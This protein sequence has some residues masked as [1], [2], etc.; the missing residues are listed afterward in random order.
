M[1]RPEAKAWELVPDKVRDE[2][3]RRIR[4]GAGNAHALRHTWRLLMPDYGLLAFSY[5][6]HKVLRWMG[7]MLLLTIFISNL[8]FVDRPLGSAL[9][10]AQLA[11]SAV[12]FAAPWLQGIPLVGRVATGVWVFMVLNVAL[13]LG[14]MK[15]LSGRAMP[16]W[17][18]TS[19]TA[20]RKQ[21][22]RMHP[23]HGKAAARSQEDSS[24]A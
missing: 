5:W 22:T 6:S 14:T 9:L 12:G 19:R 15:Y 20:E 16:V 23:G 21:R 1:F 2:F 8:W 18:R 3:R 17:Q 13:L 10:I 24:A 4:V 11:F 7:P